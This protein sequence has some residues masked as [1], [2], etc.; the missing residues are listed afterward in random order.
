[1]AKKSNLLIISLLITIGL[2]TYLTIHHYGLKLGLGGNSLCSISSVINCDAAA[3]SKY[4]EVAGVPIAVVGAVFSF[5]LLCFVGFYQMGFIEGSVY[6]RTTV[7]GMLT[8]A[9]VTSVVFGFLSFFVVRVFCPFCTAT[10]LFAIL[11]LFLG[12]GL[13]QSTDKLADKLDFKNYFG[14][15]KSH[16]IAIIFVPALSWMISGMIEKNYGLDEINKY[17]PSWIAQ[18]KSSP[19]YPFNNNVGLSNNINN[20]KFTLVEFADFKCPHCKHASETI[21]IFLKGRTDVLFIYKPYPLDGTCNANSAHKGDGSRCTLAGL[22]LCAEKIA[23]KGWEMHHWIFAKQEEL[24]SLSDVKLLL[25]QIEKD[26]GLES[27]QLGECADSVETFAEIKK[28]TEE[29]AMAKVE[30]TPT[31][32]MNGKSLPK[33]YILEVLKQAVQ[34]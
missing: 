20:P 17:I 28:S 23:K 2:F 26:L 6:L 14:E 12:W 33:G 34:D 1:M 11:N 13:I 8:L 7:R 27:K 30:A 32:F 10:Y 22:A 29:G 16:V 3:T 21:D 19:E 9:V 15:Y 18:W 25:P 24:L 31:I 5:I 4:A